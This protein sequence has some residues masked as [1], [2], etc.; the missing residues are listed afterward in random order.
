MEI[1]FI[2]FKNGIPSYYQVAY[3]VRDKSTFERELA[4]LEKIKNN[5]EKFI[6]TMDSGSSNDN[7]IKTI[8]A[9]D[10]LLS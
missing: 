2:A 7:G 8:N 1:D 6:I 10:F 9:L 4:P 3:T 5:Y